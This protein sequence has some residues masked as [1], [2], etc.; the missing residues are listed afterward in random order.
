MLFGV[1]RLVRPLASK[2]QKRHKSEPTVFT[3]S[4]FHLFFYCAQI[5]KVS[6]EGYVDAP[7]RFDS[8]H[9]VVTSYYKVILEVPHRAAASPNNKVR[10]NKSA[11][12]S[13]N[14]SAGADPGQR[15]ECYEHQTRHYRYGEYWV[16]LG[17]VLSGKKEGLFS[18]F[19]RWNTSLR[20]RN[21]EKH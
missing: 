1:L 5:R 2:R 4:L 12:S 15:D 9:S 13:V 18:I 11:N 7:A 6:T 8:C 10:P 20:R 3:L 19:D 17:V 16:G 21:R 14:S